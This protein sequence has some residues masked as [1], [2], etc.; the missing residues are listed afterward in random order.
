MNLSMLFDSFSFTSLSL[1]I[2]R[3]FV[4]SFNLCYDYIF[5]SS[6]FWRKFRL[7]AIY[8]QWSDCCLYFSCQDEL[9]EFGFDSF[10]ISCQHQIEKNSTTYQHDASI[11][12]NMRLWILFVSSRKTV[13][14]DVR[15]TRD[16]HHVMLQ[17]TFAYYKF[18][19]TFSAP[20]TD[21]YEKKKLGH[22]GASK[23][24]PGLGRDLKCDWKRNCDILD[25]TSFFIL[26]F[27]TPKKTTTIVEQKETKN[28]NIPMIF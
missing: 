12:P 28:N 2:S 19:V 9:M 23:S 11:A 27:S 6:L 1:T 18:L 20:S 22:V 5:F 10:Q 13:E 21:R 3:F 14:Q 25:L 26:F 24:T 16:V 8:H 4:G 17:I 15:Q 7:S